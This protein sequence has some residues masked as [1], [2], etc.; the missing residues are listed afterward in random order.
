M[1]IRA[2]ILITIIGFVVALAFQPP[3]IGAVT[4]PCSNCHTMHNSQGGTHMIEYLGPDETDTNPKGLLLRATCLGCHG[5]GTGNRIETIGSTEVPQV[6]HTD[7]TDLAGGNFAYITAF[8][9]KGSGASDAKG[10]NVVDFGN[11]DDVLNGPPGPINQFFHD[12]AVLDTNLTCAGENGCHGTNRYLTLG[13]GIIALKGAHHSNVDGKCDT[14]D[15]VANSYRFLCG[16][17]GLENTTDRWQNKDEN[18]HNE[19]FGTTTP[20]ILGCAG[21]E[22]GCH[23]GACGPTSSPNGSISVFCGTCHGL[24]HT[25]TGPGMADW[26]GIGRTTS[27]P[28]QRH[29]TDIALPGSGEYSAYTTYST[30]APIARTTVPDTPSPIVTPGT[31][32]VVMCLSCHGAHATDYPDI[33]R[34]NYDTMNAGGGGLD[35]GC[36]TCHTQKND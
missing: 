35:V 2:L 8:G 23:S 31:T 3:A 7:G 6:F 19:Y 33:L 30:E 20:L 4:G 11:P 18:S 22:I 15:T 13:S 14:A 32:D 25:L 26:E 24:F 29:P 17:K 1:R 16:V 34:W 36:F 9:G 21:G 27:S 12:Q 5:M 10:H 28:F